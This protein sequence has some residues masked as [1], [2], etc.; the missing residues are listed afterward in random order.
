MFGIG[1]IIEG[2]VIVIFHAYIDV[3]VVIVYWITNTSC[4]CCCCCRCS[5]GGRSKGF[6]IVA[7]AVVTLSSEEVDF[8]FVLITVRSVDI[9][10]LATGDGAK[11]TFEVP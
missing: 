8:E 9:D 10:G 5:G 3:T 7:T 4:C 2:F 1:T 11:F 6:D